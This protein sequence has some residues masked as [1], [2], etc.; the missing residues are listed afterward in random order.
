MV[1]DGGLGGKEIAARTL[2]SL[3]LYH[4]EWKASIV[5]AGGLEALE[6][7]AR[8]GT[9]VGGVSRRQRS[10]SCGAAPRTEFRASSKHPLARLVRMLGLRGEAFLRFRVNRRRLLRASCQP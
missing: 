8:Y 2:L 3:A 10:L 1:R 6:A 7:L 5:A 4:D 9:L